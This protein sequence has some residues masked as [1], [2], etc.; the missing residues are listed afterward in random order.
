MSVR[1]PQGWK[2]AWSENGVIVSDPQN[3]LISCECG[4]QQASGTSRQ[5][6]QAKLNSLK[7]QV[8]SL[9]VLAEKQIASQPD[10]YGV[11]I[12]YRSKG[13]PVGSVILNVTEDG[14]KF[15]MRSYSAPIWGLD[16]IW[17]RSHPQ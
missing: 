7:T 17:D 2:V 8:Q 4:T 16:G 9:R 3:P 12:I 1:H 10:I 6:T 11:K 14:K 15:F 5:L 13:V